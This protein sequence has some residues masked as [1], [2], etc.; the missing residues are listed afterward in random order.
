MAYH[1]LYVIVRVVVDTALPDKGEIIRQF[2]LQKEELN[3]P[4]TPDI[5]VRYVR[6]TDTWPKD[7]ASREPW[8]L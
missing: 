1:A 3:F 4:G 7:P 8:T 2:E 6:W 5:E